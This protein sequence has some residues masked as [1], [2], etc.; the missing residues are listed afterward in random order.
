MKHPIHFP[1]D[2][3]GTYVVM[4]LGMQLAMAALT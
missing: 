2:I 4:Y 1:V 3:A